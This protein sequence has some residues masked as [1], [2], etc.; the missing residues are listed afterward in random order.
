[1]YSVSPSWNTTTVAFILVLVLGHLRRLLAY[2][3]ILG[4]ERWVMLSITISDLYYRV[5][6]SVATNLF[7]LDA[8][9]R[10]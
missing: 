9:L 3:K 4:V 6:D 8:K 10:E 5:G 2:L 1:M 7:V